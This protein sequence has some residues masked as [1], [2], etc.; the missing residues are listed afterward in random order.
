MRKRRGKRKKIFKEE[1]KNHRWKRK[2]VRREGKN[3]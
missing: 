2:G 3:E 1:W